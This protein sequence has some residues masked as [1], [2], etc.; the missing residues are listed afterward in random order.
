MKVE[1]RYFGEIEIGEEKIIHFENGLL[2][3][4][5]YKDYT[6]LY[7]KDAGQES[8]FSWLQS[9]DEKGLAFPVVN[10]FKVKPDYNPS[11]EE[12]LLRPIG[13]LTPEDTVI[14]LL[15]T[16]PKDFKLAS[17]NMKAPLIINSDTRKG[18]QLILENQNY[19]IKYKLIRDDN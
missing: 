4:E 16:V 10:P 2:G 3:F 17:V 6:L 11:V 7:D 15:A 13:G 9:V 14:L 8:F 18:V 5:E 19:E 1:T 12:E